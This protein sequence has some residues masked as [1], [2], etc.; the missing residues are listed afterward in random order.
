[1]MREGV[2]GIAPFERSFIFLRQENKIWNQHN[3][4]VYI[5]LLRT[6]MFQHVLNEWGVIGYEKLVF[7]MPNDSHAADIVMQAFPESFMIFL[8]RDGRD[9]MKSRFSPF[10]SRKLAETEDME[11]RRHAIAFYSH[12]WN[13]QVDIMKAAYVAHTP[14]RRLLLRYEDLRREPSSQFK[15]M[16][17][18]IGVAMSDAELNAMIKATTLENIPD[19]Q[20]GPDKPRQTGQVG[21]FGDV[22]SDEEIDLMEIIMGSNLEEFGYELKH[23][24]PATKW[25]YQWLK[26][27]GIILGNPTGLYRDGWA[28]PRLR[29]TIQPHMPVTQV[30]IRGW[31]P[32]GMPAG[33]QI[34]MHIAGHCA[35]ARLDPGVFKLSF[36]L[37]SITNA[38]LVAVE[39]TKCIAPEGPPGR[40]L[41]FVLMELELIHPD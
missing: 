15:N 3:W 32:D 12:F 5:N 21:Q 28:S 1:M 19:D 24:A 8:M 33:G 10:A 4:D 2:T 37:D 25:Q 38:I 11:L 16:F 14:N 9:V 40:I 17:E 7:K 6:T 26:G 35:T 36:Y 27:R 41:S 22:F 31:V 29:L 34:T 23:H 30:T 39:A 18:Q 20:K 13:F